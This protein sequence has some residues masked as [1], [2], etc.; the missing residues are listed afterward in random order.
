MRLELS[1]RAPADLDEI[2]DYSVAEFGV[3][4]ATAYLDAVEGAFRRILDFPEIGAMQ[5]TVS[6]PTGPWG[7]D[8]TASST[9]SRA[10]GSW[11]CE[12][13]TRRWTR[14]GIS[15]D[16]GKCILSRIFISEGAEARRDQAPGCM[17]SQRFSALHHSSASRAKRAS[18]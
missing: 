16:G 6:P 14:R 11:S 9:P 17:R 3:G 8:C 18:R 5:A 12:S 15:E 2:R 1:R 10:R 4:G 7:V 13:C